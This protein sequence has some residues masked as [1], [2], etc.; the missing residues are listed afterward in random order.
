MV[1][2]E[3]H[4]QFSYKKEEIEILVQ[5]YNTTDKKELLKL[6]KEES[7]KTNSKTIADKDPNLTTK[8]KLDK[9]KLANETLKAWDRVRSNG[10]TPEDLNRLV[11]HGEIPNFEN[12]TPTTNADE[13]PKLSFSTFGNTVKYTAKQIKQD[14]DTLRCLRC[15]R[16]IPKLKEDWKQVDNFVKHINVDHEDELTDNERNQLMQ[17]YQR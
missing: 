15:N 10:G 7:L 1:S 16:A 8:E 13:K 12:T 5:K 2:R 11:N 14:D 17:V 4:F 6:I 9:V 3:G